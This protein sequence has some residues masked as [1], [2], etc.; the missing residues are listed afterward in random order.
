MKDYISGVLIF[1]ITIFCI[2]F[3]IQDIANGSYIYTPGIV[4]NKESI[5]MYDEYRNNNTIYNIDVESNLGIK[6]FHISFD[7]YKKINV[8]E[9]LSI[10]EFKGKSGLVWSEEIAM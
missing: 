6:D 3:C 7:Q 4:V 8:G 2:F 5:R 1:L 10:K 9:G